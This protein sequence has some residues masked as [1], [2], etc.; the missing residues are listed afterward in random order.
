MLRIL[1]IKQLVFF[2]DGLRKVKQLP[3]RSIADVF[4]RLA[5]L[6]Q[7]GLEGFDDRVMLC[8]TSCRHVEGDPQASVARIPNE[9]SM[10]D[11]CARWP[12]H[13]CESGI[14]SQRFH[15]V[16]TPQGTCGG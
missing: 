11:T 10:P 9:R 1:G 4:L 7:P 12:G 8:C 15:R 6:P 16:T 3:Y 5:G 13:R 2:H 14:S